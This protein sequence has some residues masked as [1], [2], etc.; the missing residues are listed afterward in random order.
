MEPTLCA[1]V[2]AC[3]HDCVCIYG[4]VCAYMCVGNVTCVHVH[5]CMPV[6]VCVR[7][8]SPKSN[9]LLA[10]LMTRARNM[11]SYLDYFLHPWR[12]DDA[13]V[14]IVSHLV[15]NWAVATQNQVSFLHIHPCKK[16]RAVATKHDP[17]KSKHTSMKAP[18]DT[19]VCTHIYTLSF[20][21]C[22]HLHSSTCLSTLT[23]TQ[24]SLVSGWW[25]HHSLSKTDI[26]CRAP[27]PHTP[28][29]LNCACTDMSHPHAYTHHWHTHCLTQY[30]HTHML[31]SNTPPHTHHWHP[32]Y[33]K[34]LA[35]SYTLTYSVTSRLVSSTCTG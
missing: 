1:C 23:P 28:P 31:S 3:M 29:T 17:F 4:C 6:C 24:F 13:T 15:H 34:V 35:H 25:T 5:E 16:H 32:Y 33:D 21:S 27:P 14:M 30:L 7:W 10:Y 2:R 22:T 26:S 8:A 9:S 12:D 20:H 18:A 11:L 19:N